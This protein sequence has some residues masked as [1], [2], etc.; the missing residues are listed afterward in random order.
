[1]VSESQATLR[2]RRTS[3]FPVLTLA[4][5]DLSVW[6]A[7][8]LSQ[9]DDG[10]CAMVGAGEHGDVLSGLRLDVVQ[11]GGEWRLEGA[12]AALTATP[13]SDRVTV[14]G[15]QAGIEGW[16]QLVRV[17]GRFEQDGREHTVDCLGLRSALGDVD[18][19]RIESIRAVSAWFN[20]NEA[21]ALTA[22]RPRKAKAHDGD[23]LTAAVIEA[24]GSPPVED[25]RL[26]TTYAADGWPSR[27]GIELWLTAADGEQQYPRRASGEAIGAR[28]AAV[29]EGFEVR[30]EPFRWHS[31]AREGAGMY[32]LARRR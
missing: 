18:L 24:E 25:P 13:A 3:L 22:L 11:D 28:A 16:D 5:G 17:S 21:M 19:G 4:F 27:A 9:A 14:G 7:S 30:A 20:E 23:V 10:S 8:W 26:S 31:R 2:P 15:E 6:G 12:G 29:V 32:L 1:L